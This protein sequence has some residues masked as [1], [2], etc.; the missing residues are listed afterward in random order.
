[1]YPHNPD[2][3]TKYSLLYATFCTN[4]HQTTGGM[5]TLKEALNIFFLFLFNFSF[6]FIL[7]VYDTYLVI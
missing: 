7:F 6:W 3:W 5:V 2:I 1:M 4:S